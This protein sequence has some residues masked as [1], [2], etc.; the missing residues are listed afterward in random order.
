MYTQGQPVPLTFSCADEAGG[1]GMAATDGC[2][3][4]TASGSNLPTGT[5]GMQTLTITATDAVGNVTAKTVSYRVLDATNTPGTVGGTVGATLGLT[6][7]PRRS[8][9]RSRPVSIATTSR[10]RRPPWSPP[11]VTRRS[12]SPIRARPTPASS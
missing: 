2:V 9:A 4:S 10:R 3:G 5:A 7:G 1:S 8:S 12:A 6:M 11:R